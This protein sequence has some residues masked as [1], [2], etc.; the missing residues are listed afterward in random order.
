MRYRSCFIA[1]MTDAAAVP[2]PKPPSPL[3]DF[4]PEQLRDHPAA[5]VI[6]G[7]AGL[8]ALSLGLSAFRG[9]TR[10]AL[11]TIRRRATT[12]L[13][14]T[15]RDAAYPWV[16]H[17][18][19]RT[20]PSAS[21]RHASVTTLQSDDGPTFDLVPAPGLHVVRHAGRFILVD[22]AR[23]YGTVNTSSGTPWEKVVLTAFAGPGDFFP[24][25]LEDARRD[26]EGARD[27]RKTTLYTCWGTEWRPFGQARAKRPLDSVVLKAGQAELLVHDVAEWRASKKWYADR[28]VPYRRGYLLHGPPGGGKTSFFLAL[29]GALDLDVCLLSLS[30]DGLTDDRLALALANAPRDCCVLLEDV[31]AAFADRAAHGS[32]SSGHLT[33]SGLLNALDG[34]AAAEGRVVLMTTNYVDRLDAALIRPG[35][36]DV[37]ELVDD[38]DADQAARLFRRFYDDAS[39][40]DAS[41]FGAAACAARAPSMAELQGFLIA[42]K[43]DAGAALAEASL[44]VRDRRAAGPASGGGEGP[45]TA[46]TAKKSRGRRRLA[47]L[48][49]DRMPFNPQPGWEEEVK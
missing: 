36:V 10:L 27:T 24:A 16:L 17:W 47:A 46:P 3:T 35:R 8:A 4:L 31:D 48:D 32:T 38:A 6:A 22:R 29:A 9:T 23:E 37:V 21:F 12:T 13:E 5:A 18:L 7:G 33:L 25:L 40:A 28:G 14:V 26:A 1:E 39:D 34:A 2:P 43:G 15:S 30:D 49:V 45:P 11:S 20:H 44:V 42:R 41:T 19:K